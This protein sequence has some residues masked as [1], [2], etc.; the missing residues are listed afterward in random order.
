MTNFMHILQLDNSSKAFAVA[1]SK[2][3]D[4]WPDFHLLLKI[5]SKIKQS[6]VTHLDIIKNDSNN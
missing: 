1:S 2:K 6:L 3:F 4:I 5:S